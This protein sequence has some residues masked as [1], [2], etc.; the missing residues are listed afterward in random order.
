MQKE[1]KLRI[2][3]KTVFVTTNTEKYRANLNKE[4]TGKLKNLVEKH[5]A[6][7]TEFWLAKVKRM[8][9]IN[10]TVSVEKIARKKAKHK[11][12][13]QAEEVK[14]IIQK[15]KLQESFAVELAALIESGTVN[16]DTTVE[17]ASK[18]IAEKY[19]KAQDVKP[20][21]GYRRPGE[22]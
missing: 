4:Q 1:I 14:E 16:D 19:K 21:T 10:E 13:E 2:V 17:E 20:K 9:L 3:G 11:A 5:N 18:R 8:F 22:W 6:N 7:P 12:K 15:S